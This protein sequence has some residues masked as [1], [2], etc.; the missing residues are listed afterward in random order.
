MSKIRFLFTTC[1][2]YVIVCVCV[3]VCVHACMHACVRACMRA[4]V[5]VSSTNL[6]A[7]SH[8]LYDNPTVI[9][10]TTIKIMPL[11][12]VPKDCEPTVGDR[13]TKIR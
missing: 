6:R 12:M 10:V 5:C 7:D 8:K 2:L 3:C 4:C 1:V 11:A 9:H 13:A